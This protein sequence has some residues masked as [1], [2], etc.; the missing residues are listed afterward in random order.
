MIG[1]IKLHRQILEWEWYRDINTSRL[2]IHL[3]L[4]ASYQDKRWQGIT[5]KAGSLVTS[6]ESLSKETGLTI[7]NLRTCLT[8][9]KKS[10]EVTIKITNKY[11]IITIVSFNSYQA[12]N[13]QVTSEQQTINK[14]TTNY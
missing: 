12:T 5:I 13:K 6:L 8:R 11:R 7:Q 9:L 4:K 14:R 10:K 2:F 1:F 3:L